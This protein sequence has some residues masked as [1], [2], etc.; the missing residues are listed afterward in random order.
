MFKKILICFM[1]LII[2]AVPLQSQ[3]AELEGKVTALSLDEEAPYSGI[4]LD[5]IA[6]SKMLVDQKYLRLEIE[7]NLRKEFQQ[8]LSN[9]R[10]SYD[11][12]QVDHE[13]LKK[14]HQ[15]TL[16]LKNK[17]IDDLNFLL[18]EQVDSNN[19][20]WWAIGGMAAGII[21]SIAVFYAS[22]E[23]AK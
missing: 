20:Q 1:S 8:E 19:D 15:E 5:P 12:L 2:V 22:V 14:I 17:Q 4:L 10:L 13:S 18:R 11:L 7:L 23:I 6:A 21:L 9:K 16:L 3:A